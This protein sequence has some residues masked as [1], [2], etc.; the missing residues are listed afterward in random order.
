M[1]Q[2]NLHTPQINQNGTAL[3]KGGCMKKHIAVE[4][5]AD[6]KG[7]KVWFAK[8]SPMI[9]SSLGFKGSGAHSSSGQC[10]AV[11]PMQSREINHPAG[12]GNPACTQHSFLRMLAAGTQAGRGPEQY[13]QLTH[14][15]AAL[16]THSS[17]A[18]KGEKPQS[19]SKSRALECRQEAPKS[20]KL[21]HCSPAPSCALGYRD[22]TLFIS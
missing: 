14:P 11:L 6:C 18:C 4:M 15:Q 8:V 17:A 7:A 13:I 2:R 10:L 9:S 21:L 22:E 19:S 1:I 5:S 3:F 20:C 16:A 12:Q